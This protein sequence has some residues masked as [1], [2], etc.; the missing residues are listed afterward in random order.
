MPLSNDTPNS[1]LHQSPRISCAAQSSAVSSLTPL[2]TRTLN[3]GELDDN[4]DNDH[5][6]AGVNARVD[7]DEDI[8]Q[9]TG[10]K[11][12]CDTDNFPERN[13][14]PGAK[15]KVCEADLHIEC[16]LGTAK[17]EQIPTSLS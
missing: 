14:Q 13:F 16:F 17:V 12:L 6:L 10:T 5:E 1:S 2:L 9:L 8:R 7:G 4:H 15:C 3:Y 11:I